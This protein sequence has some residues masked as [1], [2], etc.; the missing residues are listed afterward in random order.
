MAAWTY[1]LHDLITNAALAELPLANVSLSRALNAVGAFDATLDLADARVAKTKPFAATL[2]ARTALFADRNGVIV[3]AG[4]IWQ[5][6]YDSDRRTLHLAGAELMSYFAT[7][8]NRI[9]IS[10][11]PVPIARTFVARGMIDTAQD[12]VA[13]GAGSDI[14]VSSLVGDDAT[15]ST[16]STGNS[17]DLADNDRFD[18]VV[19]DLGG[20]T[21]G[22]DWA[23]ESAY[24]GSGNPT[25]VFRCY[26]PHQGRPAAVSGHI[27]EYGPDTRANIVRYTWNEDGA[28]MANAIL[29]IGSGEGSFATRAE[30]EDLT[31]ITAGYPRLEEVLALKDI[32]DAAALQGAVDARLEQTKQP[33][34]LPKVTVFADTDPA[35]GN[36]AIGD[37]A[38]IRITDLDRFPANPDG[39]PGYEGFRR[40]VGWRIQVPDGGGPE[41]VDLTLGET[42]T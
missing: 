17:F 30:A 38:L 18:K 7:R 25:K 22:F 26:A 20:V 19:A 1:R 14:G 41:L 28:R 42:L 36:W 21:N 11:G 32:T 3:W 13:Q 12:T 15:S 31:A 8:Y 23:I 2:P 5:R 24:D 4:I 34:V 27:W 6:D 29:G 37:D 35:F 40:I 10:F 39:T 9:S 16:I 33:V